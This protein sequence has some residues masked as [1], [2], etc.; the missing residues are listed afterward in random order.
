MKRER[1]RHIIRKDNSLNNL[2]FGSH[3]FFS[4]MDAVG[5]YVEAEGWV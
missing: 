3:S 2:E 1:M 5:S 4:D